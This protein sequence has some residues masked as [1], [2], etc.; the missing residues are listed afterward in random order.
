MK[1]SWLVVTIV[2][3]I[4]LLPYPAVGSVSAQDAPPTAALEPF[5]GQPVCM[6]DV[7]LQAPGS[8]LP[9][10]PSSYL[11]GLARQG[12][13]LP[14]KPLPV[15][16]AD[17]SLNQMDQS[18]LKISATSI[19]FYDTLDDAVAHRASNTVN[20]HLIYLSKLQR[21]VKDNV[22]YY[23]LTSG[24]W[25]DAG[26]AEASCCIERGRFQGLT[27]AQTPRNSFGWIL[28]PTISRSGPSY[29]SPETGKK[30]FTENVVQI[31]STQDADN[32][33]WYLV[34]PDEWIER[35][36]IRPVDINTTP[37]KG[38]TN[39]RW[40]EVN[41]YNQT[42]SVYDQGQLV[43]AT[44]IAT[45]MKPFYTRPGLFHI[46]NKKLTENMSGAFEADRSDYYY[47]EDVPWTMYY[48]DAR[49]LHGAYWR[50]LYGYP[51]SHGCVNIAPGDAHWL[52]DWANVGDWVYVWDPSGK[53]PTDP[54][55][56][57]PGGA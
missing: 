15:I 2:V 23:Q 41:L 26:Q 1:R 45:G 52:Y 8:C 53:T 18:Y 5:A 48:D 31:Y 32:T 7:Y 25:I 12:L 3:L 13:Y 51:Q 39:N 29:K 40:I 22:T 54:K 44:L 9:L 27:F 56:Y 55:Y 47:L 4:S 34:A 42:L 17:P 11:T 36:Y 6:P 24:L 20:S 21:V 16:P 57:G 19:T 10:G 38:V 50:T 30:Y 33:T 35:R 46:Q 49:A 43:F 28:E 14:L 37:P